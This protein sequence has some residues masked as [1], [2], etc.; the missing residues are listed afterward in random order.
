M[1]V[2]TSGPQD[3]VVSAHWRTGCGRAADLPSSAGSN[4]R[5]AKLHA[6]LHPERRFHDSNGFAITDNLA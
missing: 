2:V 6:E 3:G 5:V 1:M 4:F